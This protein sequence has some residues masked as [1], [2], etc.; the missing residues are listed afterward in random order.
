MVLMMPVM[1][2][3]IINQSTR[4]DSF[5]QLVLFFLR[6]LFLL[7]RLL[8]LLLRSSFLHL[9]LVPFDACGHLSVHNFLLTFRLRL[10]Y[11]IKEHLAVSVFFA[12]PWVLH[13]GVRVNY[14]GEGLR[15]AT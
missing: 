15:V 9:V 2:R 8:I 1:M 4:Q 13:F 6:L 12:D 5:R 10:N 7:V 14:L 11:P 3:R